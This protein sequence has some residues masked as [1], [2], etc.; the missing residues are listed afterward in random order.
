MLTVQEGSPLAPRFPLLFLLLFPAVL[1]AGGTSC[2]LH[3]ALVAML[4]DGA[5]AAERRHR[6]PTGFD[7]AGTR[8]TVAAT[9]F[10]HGPVDGLDSGG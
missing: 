7:T 10:A 1:P 8:H 3:T 9:V 6:P 4:E 5:H 2:Q